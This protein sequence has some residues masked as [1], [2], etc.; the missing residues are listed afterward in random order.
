MATRLTIKAESSYKDIDVTFT[1]QDTVIVESYAEGDEDTIRR[2][3][4]TMVK[5]LLG[6]GYSLGTICKYL[7]TDGAEVWEIGEE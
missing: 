5:F 3:L 7:N 4:E 1:G 2:Q 6:C